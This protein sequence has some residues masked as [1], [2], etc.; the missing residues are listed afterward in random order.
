MAPGGNRHIVGKAGALY[1][2]QGFHT[3]GVHIIATIP[4]SQPP[5]A[6]EG[7][8]HHSLTEIP[9]SPIVVGPLWAGFP[10]L[11]RVKTPTI[12]FFFFLLMVAG[13]EELPA[14]STAT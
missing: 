1:V 6:W 5:S 14:A 9:L 3:G 8:T 12:I 10:S 4:R 11:Y 13:S 7:S 2:L